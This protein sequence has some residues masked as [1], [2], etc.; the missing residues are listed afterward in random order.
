MFPPTGVISKDPAVKLNKAQ[1][2]IRDCAFLQK[3]LIVAA[4]DTLN[5]NTPGGAFMV[6]CTCSLM[7]AEN[8]EVVDY[9]LR[10]RNVKIVDAG[11]PIGEPGLTK[12]KDKK[13]D[14]SLKLTRRFYPHKHNTDGF[15]RRYD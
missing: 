1:E 2:D 10:K 5:A 11:L 7:V 6:Y 9:I 8:E 12:F 15:Y 4:I 13:F 14:P 3:E